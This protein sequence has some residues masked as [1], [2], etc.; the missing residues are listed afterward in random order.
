MDAT[1]TNTNVMCFIL[2]LPCEEAPT[3]TGITCWHPQFSIRA[4]I[5]I[6]KLLTF[7]NIEK[8][9]HMILKSAPWKHLQQ[10][11]FFFLHQAFSYQNLHLYMQINFLKF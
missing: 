11:Y 7:L 9:K 5:V 1:H 2:I 4:F 8:T 6:Y 3:M 10:P